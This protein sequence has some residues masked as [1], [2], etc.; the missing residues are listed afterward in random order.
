MN[1]MASRAVFSRLFPHE[2]LHE[3]LAVWPRIEISKEMINLLDQGIL[4]RCQFMKRRIF[5]GESSIAYAAVD[6]RDGM[7]GHT[8]EP[9]MGFRRIDLILDRLF[10]SAIEEDCMIMASG[11]PF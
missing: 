8:T 9:I 5:N 1:F 10:P 11:A 4:R 6:M 3:C 2:R 7:T